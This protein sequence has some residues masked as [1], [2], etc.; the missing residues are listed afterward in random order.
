MEPDLSHET[1]DILPGGGISFTGQAQLVIERIL[2]Q[3]SI[4]PH[5]RNFWRLQGSDASEVEANTALQ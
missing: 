5:R 1:V 2:Q 4:I 3:Q